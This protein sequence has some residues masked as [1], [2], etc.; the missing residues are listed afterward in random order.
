MFS[1]AAPGERRACY[2]PRMTKPRSPGSQRAVSDDCAAPADRRPVRGG[3]TLAESTVAPEGS[4]SLAAREGAVVIRD[5]PSHD[6]S[7]RRSG[8]AGSAEDVVACATV[9]GQAWT[10]LDGERTKRLGSGSAIL[11]DLN[12][13]KNPG[14]HSRGG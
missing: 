4:V 6:R 11:F 13:E 3:K 2:V 10:F 8:A 7:E 14:P 1:L 5:E 12:V 9:I